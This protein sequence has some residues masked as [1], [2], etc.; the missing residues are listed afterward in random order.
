MSSSAPL[1]L[2]LALAFSGWGIP[3]GPL[4]SLKTCQHA[5]AQGSGRGTSSYPP[6]AWA[7]TPR[8]GDP[9]PTPAPAASL[10]RITRTA[11]AATVTHKPR[12]HSPCSRA[13]SHSPRTCSHTHR[14]PACSHKEPLVV[15]TLARSHTP[16]DH[17][18]SC[19]RGPH[20][21]TRSLT[22]W[23]Q[24]GPGSGDYPLPPPACSKDSLCNPGSRRSPSALSSTARNSQGP[25]TSPD[26][27]VAFP[28]G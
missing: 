20:L 17:Q 2:A 28:V 14:A 5:G 13:C 21:H 27:R 15:D 16:R 10:Q 12:S 19:A 11:A 6:S 26:N 7:A 1:I 25:A 3:R 4:R 8:P 9:R 24:I 22:L 23:S 18:R